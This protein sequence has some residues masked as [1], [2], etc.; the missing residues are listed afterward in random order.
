MYSRLCVASWCPARSLQSAVQSFRA[1]GGATARSVYLPECH[2]VAAEYVLRGA[3]AAGTFVVRP[4]SV[5]RTLLTQSSRSK[6]CPK[7]E[8]CT[9]PVFAHPTL[10]SP[11]P[12]FFFPF[13]HAS[14]HS[15]GT[16]HKKWKASLWNPLYTFGEKC[17]T[18]E[19]H[20]MA[21]A[22]CTYQEKFLEGGGISWSQS[23]LLPCPITGHSH[24]TLY[25]KI[26][27]QHCKYFQFQ[28][29]VI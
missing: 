28:F 4:P 5:K 27:W 14:K 29:H 8:P 24:S 19:T 17:N 3:K 13:L 10:W 16:N 6:N 2:Q 18:A 12:I 1:G 23:C 11:Y 20:Q 7:A 22:Y 21:L 25:I 26:L 15:W 9:V